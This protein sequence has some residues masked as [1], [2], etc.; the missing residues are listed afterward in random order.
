MKV[1]KYTDNSYP[2]RLLK[3]KNYPKI[4]YVEGNEK[5]LNNDSI[6]IVG[7]RKCTMYGW[8]Q[9]ML[10]GKQLSLNGIC[11]ISGM[12]VG[13]DKAAH[14]GAKNNWG[15][16]IAV[17]GGGFNN[18]YP[19]DNKELYYEIIQN[20][21]CVITEYEPDEKT[22][23]TNFPKRNRIISGIARGTLVIEAAQRSGSLITARYTLEQEKPLFC[24]PSNLGGIKGV[25]TNNL[26][27]NGA[28]LTTSVD[29]I[30]QKL[31]IE[32]K[33]REE[34]EMNKKSVIVEKEYKSVYNALENMPITV[35]EISKRSKKS[36]A[37]T[38]QILTMLELKGI[39]QSHPGGEYSLIE[40]K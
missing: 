1:I 8:K 9:A 26:I 15:K 32:K 39:I 13:I 16:T 28:I 11:V 22:K 35:D 33:L 34:K 20:G 5:I 24:I 37:Q 36:I 12:A 21:G 25:G 4:L 2:Q 38:N 31:G 3:I 23:P 10:F 14:I 40:G 6:A 27:K 30:F 19:E 18:I 7:S 17:L 29:D